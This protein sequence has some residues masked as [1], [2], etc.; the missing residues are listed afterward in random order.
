MSFRTEN[1][2]ILPINKNFEF[3]NWL[4]KNKYSTL[5]KKRSINSIYFDTKNFMIYKDSIEGTT[6][7]KKIRIRTYSKQIFRQQ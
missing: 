6:P 4:I 1:K 5:Y 2:F 3:K 7:R